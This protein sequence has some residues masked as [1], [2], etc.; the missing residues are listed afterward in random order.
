MSETQAI[1]SVSALQ[2]T[3]N[4]M[5]AEAGAIVVKNAADYSAVAA[6]L[7]RLRNIKKQI[8][9]LL[10]PGIQSATA[11]LNG[12]REGKAQY[13]RQI[14]TLDALASRPAEEWKRQ[15]RLAAEAEQRR[16][17]EQ[18]RIEAE[19]QAA[20]QKKLADQAAEAERK[21][22]QK[23][24][25]EARKAGEIGKREAE[26]LKKQSEEDAARRK[27][28]AAEDAKNAAQVEEITV[29]AGVPKVA[30]V[31]GRV[32]YSAEVTNELLLLHAYVDA[33]L[34]HNE[35]R[36]LYL[37][38]FLQAN[39]QELG[40]EA[41]AVKNSAKLNALIPGVKFHDEDHV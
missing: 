33:Y 36:V 9:F 8:G 2:A 11:H 22:Q 13:V 40:K 37:R 12:L 35:P 1:T 32:N 15:E 4:T 21:R 6:F 17:N 39:E 5:K 14:E 18:R 20:E 3:I 10:D 27:E 41:R 19:R 34:A 29:E 31:R 26:K 16:L 23:Q 7:I 38:R 25:E 24:I 28:Q 30:G